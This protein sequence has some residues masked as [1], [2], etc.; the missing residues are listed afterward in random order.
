MSAKI[1]DHD[2]RPGQNSYRF[3]L[4]TSPAADRRLPS[5][6]C[7]GDQ[8]IC[9]ALRNSARECRPLDRILTISHIHIGNHFKTERPVEVNG[10]SS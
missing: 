2:R 5:Q 8:D 6:E 9:R 3:S 1:H 10:E 7:S 4:V